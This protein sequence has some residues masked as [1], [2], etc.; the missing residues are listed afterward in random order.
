MLIHVYYQGVITPKHTLSYLARHAEAM[1][2]FARL[3]RYGFVFMLICFYL[4]ICQAARK[5]GPSKGYVE[6]LENRL[7]RMEA[8]LANLA[9]S[10]NA[11][12][13][14][15]QQLL[16]EEKDKTPTSSSSSCAEE[17]Q[18][19]IQHIKQEQSSSSSAASSSTSKYEHPLT[20][21]YSY[22]GSSSGIYFVAK[23]FPSLLQQR[24]PHYLS[25]TGG[26]I[27]LNREDFDKDSPPAPP[28]YGQWT[29]PPKEVVD[30]LVEL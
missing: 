4:L 7:Q 20:P 12:A 24:K 30:K 15:I 10:G 22:F 19:S 21:D 25:I 8:I 27:M 5:R 11:S 18:Q 26:D 1:E 16:E 23:Y 29:L 13:E 6:A 2:Q 14:T 9:S 28:N 3:M 17:K